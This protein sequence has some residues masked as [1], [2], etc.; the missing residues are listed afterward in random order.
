M[1]PSGARSFLQ[2]AWIGERSRLLHRLF[3]AVEEKVKRG[4]SVSAA[5]RQRWH[6]PRWHATRRVRVRLGDGRIRSLFYYWRRKG[7]TADSLMLKFNGNRP[8]VPADVAAAFTRACA[9]PGVTA[10]SQ[11]ARLV[12]MEGLSL[13]RVLGVIPD[14]VKR[15]ISR[16]FS[17]RAAADREARRAV[18]KLRADIRRRILTDKRR[19]ASILKMT[20]ALG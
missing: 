3:Q 7:R 13:A 1:P 16:A 17:E 15:R 2:P 5:L 10:L 11:A 14:K 12:D 18:K 19:S 20:E 9:V 8:P 4:C 6:G